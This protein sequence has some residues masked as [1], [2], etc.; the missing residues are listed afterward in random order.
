V[1]W[2]CAQLHFHE[3]DGLE[4]QVADLPR[5]FCAAEIEAAFGGEA[6]ELAACAEDG[7][8]R[9]ALCEGAAEGIG[10]EFF[11]FVGVAE[12]EG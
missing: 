11:V 5:D 3:R 6:V 12:A 9:A 4:K 7:F 1:R 8:A 10:D 2:E